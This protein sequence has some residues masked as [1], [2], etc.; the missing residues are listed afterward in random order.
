M[1]RILFVAAVITNLI[2]AYALFAVRAEYDNLLT[3]AC[4]EASLGGHECGED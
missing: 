2:T 4:E 3:W 1:K